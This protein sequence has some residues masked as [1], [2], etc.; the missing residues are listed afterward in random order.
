MAMYT[1]TR[2][3]PQQVMDLWDNSNGHDA[4]E[5]TYCGEGNSGHDPFCQNCDEYNDVG[6]LHS[7]RAE[8]IT[9]WGADFG[10]GDVHTGRAVLITSGKGQGQVRTI[11]SYV[12]TSGLFTVTPSWDQQPDSSSTFLI[13]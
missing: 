13:T 11:T 6:L 8:K 5:C 10:D 2:L 1:A 4:Y 3:L 12:G 9:R 7:Y